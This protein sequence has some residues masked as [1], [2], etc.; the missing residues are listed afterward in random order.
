MYQTIPSINLKS[1]NSF[2]E[3]T[4]VESS[5]EISKLQESNALDTGDKC[6]LNLNRDLSE[7]K[8]HESLV[9]GSTTA[10]DVV[11]EQAVKKALAWHQAQSEKTSRKQVRL[12]EHTRVEERE[13]PEFAHSHGPRRSSKSSDDELKQSQKKSSKT[14]SR[15]KRQKQCKEP[16][17]AKCIE[18]RAKH[19]LGDLEFDTTRV[20]D[21][22]SQQG[23]KLSMRKQGKIEGSLG[24]DGVHG[25]HMP[26]L[27]S[28][29]NRVR[30]NAEAGDFMVD[31][32]EMKVRIDPSNGFQMEFD[33][34]LVEFNPVGDGSIAELIIGGKRRERGDPT[35]TSERGSEATESETDTIEDWSDAS[36]VISR[37]PN[38]P[39]L[40]K[41][42]RA[43]SSQKRASYLSNATAS[44]W[45]SLG[46]PMSSTRFHGHAA[47][48]NP[49]LGPPAPRFE[50]QHLDGGY[51]AAHG[52]WQS[53]RGP[54]WATSSYDGPGADFPQYY[55]RAMYPPRDHEN[56]RHLQPRQP[57]VIPQLD[58]NNPRLRTGPEVKFNPNTDVQ[59]ESKHAEHDTEVRDVPH[60]MDK[61]DTLLDLVKESQRMCDQRQQELVQEASNAKA[62][63]SEREQRDTDGSSRCTY[64][65][66]TVLLLSESSLSKPLLHLM[67]LFPTILSER[68]GNALHPVLTEYVGRLCE[69]AVTDTEVSV[70]RA[71]KHAL[72]RDSPDAVTR[73][74][75]IVATLPDA[76]KQKISKGSCSDKELVVAFN[77][78]EDG[79]FIGRPIDLAWIKCFES[80]Q[81]QAFLFSGGSGVRLKKDIQDLATP[82]RPSAAALRQSAQRHE[83]V[84]GIT[85]LFHVSEAIAHAEPRSV[86]IGYQRPPRKGLAPYTAQLQLMIEDIT[87]AQWD[88]WPMLPPQQPVLA[89]HE[90]L[91]WLCVCSH[92][93][94]LSS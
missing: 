93:T 31:G 86:C 36:S 43:H 47:E 6:N 60:N 71:I 89:G 50:D 28:R 17:C 52:A 58:S 27:A 78:F 84:N 25:V 57:D 9:A 40:P 1:L 72:P 85:D 63:S 13:N 24:G 87:D 65:E 70:C 69:S 21:I 74:I 79:D 3:I 48:H 90:L 59:S 49:F 5:L 39:Q 32:D 18:A 46:R 77:A 42:S 35:N 14:N 82:K 64:R 91:S 56:S 51:L 66:V 29:R 41:I 15:V 80:P 12:E 54:P 11:R 33:G 16:N 19:A 8:A 76:V 68:L 81:V 88:W 2:S 26:S 92:L 75:K 4:S 62:K 45:S 94:Q 53:R 73:L 38:A 23:E 20:P 10:A 61:L 7:G 34:R 83:G 67:A 37:R 30:S 22:V 44:T 55:N